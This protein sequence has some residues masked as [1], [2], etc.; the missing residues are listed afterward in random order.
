MA[1]DKILSLLDRVIPQLANVAS[2]IRLLFFNF[3][4]ARAPFAVMQRLMSPSITHVLSIL[5]SI[6]LIVAVICTTKDLNLFS[7]HPIFMTVGCVL[8]MSEGFLVYRNGSLV[9]IF[10]PIMGGTSKSKARAI[11]IF[12]QATSGLFMFTGLVFILANKLRAGKPVIPSTPHAWLGILAVFFVTVQGV[13]GP[14]KTASSVPIYRWHGNAGKLAYDMCMLSVLSG[15]I[16][17]LPVSSM[18]IGAEFAVLVLWL[19]SELQHSL[20]ERKS[21]DTTNSMSNSSHEENKLPHEMDTLI[22][23]GSSGAL[24]P[25][26]NRNLSTD[27]P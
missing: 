20:G 4:E 7:F 2:Q 6:Y 8:I 14:I 26:M 5:A 3:F 15:A 21:G 1:F 24:S 25:T 22:P 16:S 11:H 23:S 10:D 18:N 9:N 12:L 27:L 17:F 13:I 19:S